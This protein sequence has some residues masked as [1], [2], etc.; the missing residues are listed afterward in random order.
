MV[1]L[2]S[3]SSSSS[4]RSSKCSPRTLIVYICLLPTIFD[5]LIC[6]FC[7]AE[8]IVAQQKADFGTLKFV[9]ILWRHGAR[10]PIADMAKEPRQ[11]KQGPGELTK[12]GMGQMYRLG[13]WIRHRYDGGFL[14]PEYNVNE[15]YVRSSDFNRTLMSAQALLAGL[16]PPTPNRTFEPGLKW[17]PIPVHTEAREADRVIFDGSNCAPMLEEERRVFSSAEVKEI[18][19]QNADFLR[20]LAIQ[21]GF[22]QIPLPF[23]ETRYVFDPLICIKFNGEGKELPKWANESVIER[24]WQLNDFSSN[25][26]YKTTKLVRFRA[27]VLFNEILQ[28]MKNVQQQ[29]SAAAAGGDNNNYDGRQRVQAYSAHDTTLAGILSAFGI[30]PSPFPHFATALFIE[31]HQLHQPPQQLLSPAAAAPQFSIRLFY[32]NETDVDT[33]YE[34][35]IPDCPAPCTVDRLEHVRAEILSTKLEQDNECAGG[36]FFADKFVWSERINSITL[37]HRELIYIT[38]IGVLALLCLSMCGYIA[39]CSVAARCCTHRRKKRQWKR[40]KMK[41]AHVGGGTA[42]STTTLVTTTGADDQPLLPLE[43][44]GT[45]N[46]M[47]SSNES[48]SGGGGG[49]DEEEAVFGRHGRR[50]RSGRKLMKNQQQKL[51]DDDDDDGL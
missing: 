43:E 15:F 24:I 14:S 5:A 30:P 21:S 35:S 38:L 19:R 22:E 4:S 29:T 41:W 6:T 16:Y 49:G 50:R 11:W 42:A 18:E 20:F 1:K 40:R 32:R 25:Y 46:E 36:S 10:T 39:C 17:Q 34:L 7:C 45:I 26:L 23:R 12:K 2:S 8:Q 37:Q 9:H 48:D 51:D 27:G 47:S 31:L 3:S 28:R 33:L 44:M 13:Q